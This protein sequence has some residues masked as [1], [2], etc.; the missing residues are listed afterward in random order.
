MILLAMGYNKIDGGRE[1]V[2]YMLY[3]SN[4]NLLGLIK[5]YFIICYN[6]NDN[7][8]ITLKRLKKDT[9]KY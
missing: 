2:K 5:E 3:G 9:I 6:I 8:L 1:M 4:Y 7:I